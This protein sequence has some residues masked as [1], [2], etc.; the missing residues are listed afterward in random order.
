MKFHSGFRRPVKIRVQTES[1]FSADR[2]TPIPIP[3][4]GVSL[5]REL[6][7]LPSPDWRIVGDHE[8]VLGEISEDAWL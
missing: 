6:D 4:A 5:F 2:I 7:P 8:G 3:P 1:S